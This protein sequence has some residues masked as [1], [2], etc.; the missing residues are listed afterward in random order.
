V[1]GYPTIT[2]V[3]CIT[4]VESVTTSQSILL[5]SYTTIVTSS[6]STVTTTAT[7]NSS[8]VAT[9]T[10]TV[11]GKSFSLVQTFTSICVPYNSR[12]LKTN[13]AAGIYARLFQYCD[14]LCA[15]D[16]LP[17]GQ[18]YIADLLGSR[19]GYWCMTGDRDAGSDPASDY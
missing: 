17:C 2:T 14:N 7:T 5:T 13:V 15:T 8:V 12:E 1:T 18:I 3:V 9:S 19:Y 16:S 4:S 10:A 6:V 11:Q